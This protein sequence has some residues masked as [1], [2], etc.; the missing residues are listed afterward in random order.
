[1]KRGT[2]KLFLGVESTKESF[3]NTLLSLL[4]VLTATFVAHDVKGKAERGSL[5]RY[6]YSN[7][8]QD[9][10]AIPKKDKS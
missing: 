10:G 2:I 8:V 9:R 6:N 1:M 3:S 5:V 7:N 4:L